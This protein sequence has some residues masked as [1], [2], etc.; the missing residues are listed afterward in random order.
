MN[1]PIVTAGVKITRSD[2]DGQHSEK[3]S[4]LVRGYR[5]SSA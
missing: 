2:Q 4:T 1:V 5:L 3:K